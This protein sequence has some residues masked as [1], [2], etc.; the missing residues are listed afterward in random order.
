MRLG[1]VGGVPAAA[2]SDGDS[3][4]QGLHHVPHFFDL[5]LSD[6]G[7]PVAF[8]IRPAQR[9]NGGGGQGDVGAFVITFGLALAGG[10]PASNEPPTRGPVGRSLH[11]ERATVSVFE[12]QLRES[13]IPEPDRRQR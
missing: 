8:I 9:V 11:C 7:K 12:N 13:I 5:L 6:N 10:H 2:R 3:E 1:E 4:S